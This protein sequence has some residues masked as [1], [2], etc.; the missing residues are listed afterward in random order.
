VT[1]VKLLRVSVIGGD[2]RVG[3]KIVGTMAIDGDGVISVA[4][5]PIATTV[6]ESFGSTSLVEVGTNYFL[7][8]VGGSSGPEL[9]LSGAPVVAGQFGSWTPLGAEQTA[10][11]YEVAWKV[12]G[13][14]Q[15]SVWVTDSSGSYTSNNGA[16]AP[17][18]AGTSSALEMLEP[19][20]HQDLNGDG[21]IG[22]AVMS[23]GT[24]EVSSAYSG[25]ATFMGSSGILQLDQSASFS[26]TVAGMTGQDTLDLRD[27]SF[28]TIQSPTYL[29]TSTGGTLSVSDGKLN[30]QIALL[31]N[32]LASTFVASSDGHGGTNVVDPS[33][34]R[35]TSQTS[36]LVQPY[37]A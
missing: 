2:N 25:P 37:H 20:F 18:V 34:T 22:L 30:A 1:D 12:T 32:Y 10:S 19:S 33:A 14:D 15:Y 27:I 7:Y 3:V 35:E 28:A 16:G 24:V 9:S 6:I 11:G 26:G 8:P 21:V 23:G 29:G 4:P 36:L 5:A 31:G 17:G 13:A